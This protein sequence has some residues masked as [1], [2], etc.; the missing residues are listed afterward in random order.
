M[1]T[2]QHVAYK[3]RYHLLQHLFLWSMAIFIM[4]GCSDDQTIITNNPLGLTR[5]SIPMEIEMDANEVLTMRGHGFTTADIIKFTGEQGEYTAQLGTVNPDNITYV[6]PSDIPTGTYQVTV[7]RNGDTMRLS[8]TT[9][10]RVYRGEVADR[11]GMNLKGKVHCCGAPLAGVTVS[12]GIDITTTDENGVYYLDSDKKLGYV[13]ISLPSG[14]KVLNDGNQPQIYAKLSDDATKIDRNDFSLI[15]APE[16]KSYV[17]LTLADMH[18]AA[19]TYDRE[20]YQANFLPDVNS[21]IA[22]YKAE[23]KDVW[24]ITLG[25]QSWDS[26]WYS[27]KFTLVDAIKYVSQIDCPVFHCIGN[28]DNDPNFS[29]D[30]NATQLWRTNLGPTYYSFNIG[31]VHY[32]VLDNITYNGSTYKVEVD[33]AQMAWF[34]ADLATISDKTQPLVVCM[35]APL[36]SRPTSITSAGGQTDKIG[37]DNSSAFISLLKRFDDVSI[38][39]GHMHMCYTGQQN[40]GKIYEY[41]VGSVCATWWWTGHPNYP[42]KVHVCTDGAPGGYGVVEVGG[43]K[44][45]KYYYKGLG[46]ASDYQFRAY[47]LNTVEI[48]AEKFCP[49][50]DDARIALVPTYARGFAS[51]GSANEILVNVWGY[52]HGWSIEMTENGNPLD[53]KRVSEYDPLHIVGYEF[54]RMNVNANPTSDMVSVKNIHMFKATASSATSTVEIKVTD[55]FGNVYTESMAR[56]KAFTYSIK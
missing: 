4:A 15:K 52:G 33:D 18:L 55:R 38:L 6:L 5:V 8:K 35:H 32:V 16:D 19:R 17:M 24:A 47:D 31:N 34:E 45:E 50:A 23:G 54:Q 41:N 21:L 43:N 1:R 30:L 49:D 12:D 26:Y 39:S 40:S 20:Q 29:N 11:E 56:P 10:Y 14:Y 3:G 25:D 22:S 46:Y 37:L 28:H 48:T 9:I 7:T 51:A 13:F 36:H 42:A 2:K 53:V 27:N 44:I